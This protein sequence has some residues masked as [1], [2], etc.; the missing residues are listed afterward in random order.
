MPLQKLFHADNCCHHH[1]VESSI[2]KTSD[3][4]TLLCSMKEFAPHATITQLPDKLIQEKLKKIIELTKFPL[5]L[6]GTLEQFHKDVTD[7][8]AFSAY[9]EHYGSEESLII[10]MSTSTQFVSLRG[11]HFF[12][13]ND[14]SEILFTYLLSHF[15][16]TESVLLVTIVLF[17]VKHIG[18]QLS[19][20]YEF[21]PLD[22]FLSVRDELIN[23][24]KSTDLNRLSKEDK[25]KLGFTFSYGKPYEIAKHW[26]KL[27][28]PFFDAKRHSAFRNHLDDLG[29]THLFVWMQKG[30]ESFAYLNCALAI[31]SLEKVVNAHPEV[32]LPFTDKANVEKKGKKMPVTVRVFKETMWECVLV[33]ELQKAMRL[34]LNSE[35]VTLIDEKDP[36]SSKFLLC[37]PMK[38]V[39]STL[40]K[41]KVKVNDI[42]FIVTSIP[43]VKHAPVP[44]VSPSGVLC[45][46]ALDMLCQVLRTL[47]FEVKLFQRTK[48]DWKLIEET[49]S[50][51]Y[52]W[53]RNDCKYV[54]FITNDELKQIEATLGRLRL[55]FGTIPAKDVRN[56]KV[57]GFTVDNLKNELKHLGL[58]ECLPNIVYKADVAYAV[59]SH[60]KVGPVLQTCDLVDAIHACLVY[61]VFE[62]L[63]KL[64][65]FI[66]YQQHC[67]VMGAYACRLCD[68]NP[69]DRLDEKFLPDELKAKSEKIAMK[70]LMEM[71]GAA[72]MKNEKEEPEKKKQTKQITPMK[73]PAKETPD[74]KDIKKNTPEKPPSNVT[75]P[76]CMGHKVKAE[77]QKESGCCKKCLRTSEMCNQAKEELKMATSRVKTLE[78]K[79]KNAEKE[80]ERRL[81]GQDAVSKELKETKEL[82]STLQN[83][84]KQLLEERRTEKKE[85][86]E[87]F[88]REKQ[89][90]EEQMRRKE[91]ELVHAQIR[92]EIENKEKD[93]TIQLLMDRIAKI[94]ANSHAPKVQT[95][96]E[97]ADTECLICLCNVEN[98]QETIKCNLCKRRYHS[99]CAADWLKVKS[100]C[101]ACHSDLVAPRESPGQ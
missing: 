52:Q 16:S 4:K 69:L 90:L 59:I 63:P 15:K 64:A 22:H 11:N 50:V 67:I 41:H 61:C 79:L 100:V 58:D 51:F 23:T 89:E 44:I 80:K 13:K 26:K 37:M 39:I 33:S 10:N 18:R 92:L 70:M 88:K 82:V 57:D 53:F 84:K 30:R 40:E 6:Y 43:R 54:Y 75:S 29:N 99:K 17:Y 28:E 98:A 87:R 34:V 94:S 66:H 85:M 68:Q 73:V 20:C 95:A 97:L 78:K 86:V 36:N 56:A 74:K 49:V 62:K 14:V 19:S 71:M 2:F 3:V 93:M 46:P 12:P 91:N 25:E 65:E 45:K 60:V 8:R 101:P 42:E 76:G 77:T 35:K 83:M 55:K 38:E 31:R 96:N 21:I 81:T 27:M 5:R 48:G 32:F 9:W 47:M 1:V 24:I 7:I 72:G